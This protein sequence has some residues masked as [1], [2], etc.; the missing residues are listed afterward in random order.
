MAG[1]SRSPGPPRK[2]SYAT[3]LQRSRSPSELLHLAS[4]HA[5][6]P[7]D[8][9]S[10]LSALAQLTPRHDAS[11]RSDTRLH[12]LLARTLADADALR[13]SSLCTLLWSL[14]VLR[15]PLRPSEASMA[16]LAASLSDSLPTLAAHDAAH[17]AW[18][19]G[20]LAR[21]A[22][23]EGR[24]GAGPVPRALQLRAAT[25]P[26]AVHLAACEAALG[27][28][29][30]AVE[31]LL[32]ECRPQ[33]ERISSGSR[34]SLDAKTVVEEQRLTAWQS[35]ANM[36]F[37][38]SGKTMYPSP[39]GFT[40]RLGAV[41]DVLADRLGRRYDSCLVNYYE[42]AKVGMR[43]HSDPGQGEQ[44]GYSTAVVS[45]GATRF[46]VFREA[47]AK[48]RKC[49]FA[50]RHGD[51]VEMFAN[52]QRRYQHTVKVEA[53]AGLAHRRMSLVYKRTLASEEA[54]RRTERADWNVP[55][56]GSVWDGTPYD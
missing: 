48:E 9:V 46:F 10:L 24:E 8:A 26:F 45:V 7:H 42:N 36:P 25:L 32:A 47:E 44:W 5:P 2:L 16:A 38:Y 13:P 33:R 52:C 34:V 49:A 51:V 40:P 27:G 53:A 18:A 11:V 43:Y 4:V 19:W 29:R 35:E 50:V 39:G 30:A 54:V 3:A 37:C 41:R 21:D 1:P 22:R 55:G 15:R 17:A 31:A 23:A 20:S 28:E 14:A 12:L 56:A 6:A